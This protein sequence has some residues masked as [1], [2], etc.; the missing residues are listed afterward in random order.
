MIIC[1]YHQPITEYLTELPYEINNH[2]N[3]NELLQNHIS[4]MIDTLE[5]MKTNEHSDKNEL[6]EIAQLSFKT[7]S[8]YDKQRKKQWSVQRSI[9]EYM[10][11][12]KDDDLFDKLI[13]KKGPNI[14]DKNISN[15]GLSNNK[16]I[17]IDAGIKNNHD[18]VDYSKLSTQPLNL[19]I[20][21][22]ESGLQ[23]LSIHNEKGISN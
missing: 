19:N 13:R 18:F 4:K 11:Y 14:P 21:S 17:M 12:L 22:L 23:D 10:S 15:M 3:R 1:N 6:L 9:D 16:I 2:I 7:T 8:D 20:S 5:N